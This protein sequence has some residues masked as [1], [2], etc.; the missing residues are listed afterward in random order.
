MVFITPPPKR[1]EPENFVISCVLCGNDA[2]YIKEIIQDGRAL[3]ICP[4][5]D[6]RELFGPHYT[7]K[8]A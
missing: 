1:P 7:K 3:F 8:G 2:A 4:E 5:C 6:T